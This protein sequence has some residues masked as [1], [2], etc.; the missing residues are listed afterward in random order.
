MRSLCVEK[1]TER[2]IHESWGDKTIQ[3]LILHEDENQFKIQ[4]CSDHYIQYLFSQSPAVPQNQTH[5]QECFEN[6]M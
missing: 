1:S 5:L 4:W 6:N 2:Y 3:N